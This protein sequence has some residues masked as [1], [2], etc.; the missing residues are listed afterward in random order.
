MVFLLAYAM[1]I[2]FFAVVYRRRWPAFVAI[3]AGLPP[4][5]I[6]A[7][8][9]VKFLL[10]PDPEGRSVLIYTLAAALMGL[11]LA[12]GF[13]IALLPRRAPDVPCRACGYDLEGN[14][15][16]VC[17]E[18]GWVVN[19]SKRR[20]RRPRLPAAPAPAAPETGLASRL[21]GQIAWRAA[22][23]DALSGQAAVDRAAE[24][25]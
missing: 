15:S 19:T 8:A 2:W 10:G 18:C 4:V 9:C 5:V 17:P 13:F 24:V 21:S 14:V 1:I 6:V 25:R 20:Q 16:G 23:A 11:I 22:A 3:A 7:T 12:V